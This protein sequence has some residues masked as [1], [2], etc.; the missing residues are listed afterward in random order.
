MS[1]IGTDIV[2]ELIYVAK[3]H[4]ESLGRLEVLLEWQ[5]AERVTLD[6]LIVMAGH[7]AG[8]P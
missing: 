6:P 7:R 4:R 5:P 1:C 2:P 8:H 3:W